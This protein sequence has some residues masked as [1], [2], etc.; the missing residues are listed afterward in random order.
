MSALRAARSCRSV[1]HGGEVCAFS[2]VIRPETL[3]LSHVRVRQGLARAG[4][5][6]RRRQGLVFSLSSVAANPLLWAYALGIQ[7]RASDVSGDAYPGKTARAAGV[8]SDKPR[9]GE[10]ASAMDD[11]WAQSKRCTQSN[12]S[13]KG[14][15]GVTTVGDVVPVSPHANPRHLIGRC[16]WRATPLLALLDPAAAACL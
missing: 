9:S 4:A 13:T 5:Q 2:R 15:S 7:C 8:P 12:H 16:H 11:T 3:C 1:V 10:Q 14:A 6:C